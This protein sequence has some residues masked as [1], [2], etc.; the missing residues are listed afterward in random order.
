MDTRT[1]FAST[2]LVI[3]ILVIVFTWKTYPYAKYIVMSR[4]DGESKYIA[5][6]D[7]EVIDNRGGRREIVAIEGKNQVVYGFSNQTGAVAAAAGAQ[8]DITFNG[9]NMGYVKDTGG[10]GAGIAYGPVMAALS[11]VS[12]TTGYI[13]FTLGCPSKIARLNIKAPDD[14]LSRANLQRVKVYLL[15]SDKNLISGAEQVIPVSGTIASTTHHIS[16]V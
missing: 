10:V 11:S 1:V 16:F 13:I 9:R 6:R 3:L 7:M 15:D 2:L 4:T 5:V 14:D 12:S 8:G